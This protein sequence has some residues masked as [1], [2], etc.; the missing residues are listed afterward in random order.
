[1]NTKKAK[2]ARRC[3]PAKCW[4]VKTGKRGEKKPEFRVRLPDFA[5][6]IG[7]K[8]EARYASGE[9]DADRYQEI[10]PRLNALL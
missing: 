1:M 3:R 7:G 8:V 4:T 6:Q 10:S 5:R 9:L 2:M